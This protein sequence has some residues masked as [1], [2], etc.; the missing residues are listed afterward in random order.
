MNILI[1]TAKYG[2]GHYTAAISLK[3]ELENKNINVRVVDFFELIFPKINKVIYSIFNILVS[4]FCSIY[5]FF[6]SFSA[7]NNMAPFKNI[8]RIVSTFPVCSKYIS[9]YK[10][11][12]YIDVKLYTYITDIDVNKEWI[13]DETNLYFVASYETQRQML[14]YGISKDK[15]KVVGIPVRQEFKENVDIKNK[16]EIV[17]MGGGLGLISSIEDTLKKL[18]ENKE[19]HV[20]LLVGKNKKLFEKYYNK[21]LNMTV[22]GYTEEVHKYIRKAELIITKPGGIT[23][24]ESIYSKTPIYVINPFLNQ[25][26]GNA[27]FIESNKIGKVIWNKKENIAQDIL[28]LL[29]APSILENMKQNMQKLKDSL[30][31]LTI[32]DCVEGSV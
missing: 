3:Q 29:K 10:K 24:F 12:N 30:E 20:T 32:I 5:N 14:K 7:N 4:K 2:M 26:L 21:Y 28:N 27:K 15:I 16:N 23:L 31:N 13:T 18:L 11:K 22:I 17:V 1:L 25:E 6:Y 9:V 8:I 19:V